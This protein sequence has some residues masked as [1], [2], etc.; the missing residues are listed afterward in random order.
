MQ[1]GQRKRQAFQGRQAGQISQGRA[2]R[3][4]RLD[5]ARIQVGRQ[6]R[7]GRQASP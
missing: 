1:A 5:Q 2:V 3:K 6:G 7:V 4:G